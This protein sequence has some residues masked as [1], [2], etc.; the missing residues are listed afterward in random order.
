MLKI[1]AVDLLSFWGF[2]ILRRGSR[3]LDLVKFFIGMIWALISR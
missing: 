1:R 2:L 3:C